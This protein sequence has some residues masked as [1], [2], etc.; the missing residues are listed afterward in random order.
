MFD[1][2]LNKAKSI[3]NSSSEYV[4][5]SIRN[6]GNNIRSSV[7]NVKTRVGNIRNRVGNFINPKTPPPSQP[8][9]PQLPKVQEQFLQQPQPPRKVEVYEAHMAK[10][11]K[12]VAKI[13]SHGKTEQEAREILDT[14]EAERKALELQNDFTYNV[15]HELIEKIA[16]ELPPETIDRLSRELANDVIRVNSEGGILVPQNMEQLNRAV[17]EALMEQNN[18]L[19]TNNPNA[20]PITT[21]IGETD[22]RINLLRSNKVGTRRL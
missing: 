7:N 19:L 15:V 13:M 16:P 12:K 1:K 3:I 10:H 14:E 4:A 5:T 20:K 18:K 11:E 8:Q 21:G 6:T 9:E 22:S 2:L 17:D